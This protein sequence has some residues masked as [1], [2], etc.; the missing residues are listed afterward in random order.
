MF[1]FDNL[2][3]SYKMG[4]MN[5]ELSVETD[6]DHSNLPYDLADL[7]ARV[8][9]DSSVNTDMVLEHLSEKFEYNLRKNGCENIERWTPIDV[10]CTSK[11]V[12]L[13]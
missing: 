6:F 8:M 2:K 1:G 5:V 11:E 4:S 9:E 12:I 7:F 13:E 10:H 3:I